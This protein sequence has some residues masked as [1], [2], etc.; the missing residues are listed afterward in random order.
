MSYYANPVVLWGP[1]ALGI[2]LDEGNGDE[3]E[4]MFIEHL[5]PCFS[6]NIFMLLYSVLM[7]PFL[8]KFVLVGLNQI[9]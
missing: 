8:L 3:A 2:L 4:Y 5:L 1:V 9:I 7:V 6:V